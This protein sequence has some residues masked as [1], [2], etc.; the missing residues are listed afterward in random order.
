MRLESVVE[1][2]ESLPGS[3][4]SMD[5]SQMAVMCPWCDSDGTSKP[6]LSVKLE[7]DSGEPMLYQCF[8]ASCG[9]RGVLKTDDLR[10]LGCRDKDVINELAQHNLTVNPHLEKEFAPRESREVAL[11]NLPVGNNAE[12]LAYI[13]QRLGLRLEYEHLQELKIQ[14]S[15]LDMLRLND[16][17]KLS[18][19]KKTVRNLDVY[20]IGFISMFRDYMVCRD[21]TPDL[22]TGARYYTYRIS[23]KPDPND[24]RIYCIPRTIDLMDPRAAVINVAE[25]PFSILGAYLNTDLGR[26]RPNSLWLANCGSQYEKTILTVCRQFGL[27]KVRINIWSDSEIKIGLYQKLKKGL[28]GH[29]DIRNLCIYYNRDAE[30]FG[31]PKSRIRVEEVTL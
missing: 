10:L 1:F 6:H 20:C 3:K 7:V 12:K 21:I 9:K 4:P 18:A 28:K 13:Q 25:G 22:K 17:K 11:V 19:S 29:L 24:L 5:G 30:D 26:D 15:L 14:L 16:I 27:L 31:V 8:R 2:L 23:G